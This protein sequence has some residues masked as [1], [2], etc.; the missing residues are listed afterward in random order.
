MQLLTLHLQLK[1]LTDVSVHFTLS[2]RTNDA[3][4][5]R[6]LTM[7]LFHNYNKP[8]KINANRRILIIITKARGGSFR[9]AALGT[10]KL[11]R[12]LPVY[13]CCV[14]TV[15]VLCS[16]SPRSFA[17]YKVTRQSIPSLNIQLLA[18]KNKSTCNFEKNNCI[19]S[20]TLRLQK[21]NREHCFNE[22]LPVHFHDLFWPNVEYSN[23]IL[24][25]IFVNF[26][27]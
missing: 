20:S 16:L 5:I 13:C 18:I 17:S 8:T 3:T 21:N 14:K 27:F 15:G 12:P 7:L 10:V 2:L 11:Q 6:I 19:Y 24:V 25:V 26:T 4:L 23:G 9:P 1:L 22:V